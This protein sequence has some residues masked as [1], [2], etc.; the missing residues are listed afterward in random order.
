MRKLAIKAI[1][2][3]VGRASDT[4]TPPGKEGALGVRTASSPPTIVVA[5]PEDGLED[6]SGL[7]NV[8]KFTP[9]FLVQI[10]VR[11]VRISYVSGLL[12]QN[13][14]GS[15]L[16]SRGQPRKL[17]RSEHVPDGN[18]TIP[19]EQ[20][21]SRLNIIGIDHLETLDAVVLAQVQETR[22]HVRI[23]WASA[24]A[25]CL[26]VLRCVGLKFGTRTSC[27]SKIIINTSGVP[28]LKPGRRRTWSL[29]FVSCR[30]PKPFQ[31]LSLSGAPP[32]ALITAEPRGA[33]AG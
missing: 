10:A 3:R 19:M 9:F 17:V 7:W 1:G 32:C 12:R 6:G 18:E 13:L 28:V 23:V 27:F 21:S 5:V 22:L 16:R 20:G 8:K 29:D 25:L 11:V 30:Q 2:R 26:W 14:F 4:A 24:P 15:P 31:P 33:A